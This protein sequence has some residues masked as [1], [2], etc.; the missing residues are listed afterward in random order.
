MVQEDYLYGAG[1]S[2]EDNISYVGN[3]CTL[4]IYLL[5]EGRSRA[6]GCREQSGQ[7]LVLYGRVSAQ[8]RTGWYED[9]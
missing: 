3:R 2:A 6:A 1:V 7:W 8:S 5:K 4:W 9:L